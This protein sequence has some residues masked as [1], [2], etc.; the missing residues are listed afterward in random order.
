MRVLALILWLPLF[1]SAFLTV[2]P[3][4]NRVLSKQIIWAANDDSQSMEMYVTLPG[5][6]AITAQLKVDPI[7]SVPSE[8]VEVRYKLPF[9][10]DV[11]PMKNLAV[12]TKDGSGGER[13]N[14]V[15]RFTSYWSIGL[16]AGNGLVTTAA[17]FA[18]GVSWQCSLFDVMKAKSWEQVVQALTTN[19][20][21][22]TDEVVL[23]FER[24]LEGVAPELV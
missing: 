5:S 6:M 3:P 4:R 22:R 11:A 21:E 15:L 13:V 7:L 18:G 23:I 20:K 1:G 14:D 2:S 16:P 8:L 17:S 12:C 10:L 9:G 19:T 24:A